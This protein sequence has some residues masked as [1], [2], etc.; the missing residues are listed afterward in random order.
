MY[1]PAIPTAQVHACRNP[2]LVVDGAI[3]APSNF[4]S[5]LSCSAVVESSK[6]RINLMQQLIKYSRPDIQLT[7]SA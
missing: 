1:H 7:C 4:Q 6:L 3:G 2:L 5:Q